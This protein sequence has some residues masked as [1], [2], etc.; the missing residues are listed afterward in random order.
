M[1]T[2]M[3]PMSERMKA[4]VGFSLDNSCGV[5][6]A[7]LLFNADFYYEVRIAKVPDS[8]S[9]NT[10]GGATPANAGSTPYLCTPRNPKPVGEEQTLF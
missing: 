9:G 10:A 1:I 4:A 8:R 2:K 3:P 7:A 5:R 6:R